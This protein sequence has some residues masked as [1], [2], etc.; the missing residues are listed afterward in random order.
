ME[1]D[2]GCRSVAA[3]RRIISA[4]LPHLKEDGFDVTVQGRAVE[5]VDVCGLEEGAKIQVVVNRRVAAL[6]ALRAA[7][8][9]VSE[10]GLKEGLGYAVH[11]GNVALCE[12]YLDA[13]ATR[14]EP[15][16][17]LVGYTP[18]ALCELLLSRGW[19]VNASA[20]HTG[21]TALLHATATRQLAL[22]K[23]L[24]QHGADVD[25]EDVMGSTPLHITVASCYEDRESHEVR[26][27]LLQHGADMRIRD[28]RG[29]SPLGLA[30]KIRK[31]SLKP[32][33]FSAFKLF[34]STEPPR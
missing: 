8:H 3:L 34:A 6:K 10:D 29:V 25:K 1:L 19:D 16:E 15:S 27:V 24:L 18:L 4:A 22:C 31:K 33:R 9:D 17:P 12:R 13:G 7:G 32:R 28:K 11:R 2:E 30:R 23:L 5:D 21:F 20:V 26:E 14:R